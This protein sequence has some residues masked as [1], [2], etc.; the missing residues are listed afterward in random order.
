M[1]KDTVQ[2][3]LRGSISEQMVSLSRQ[4]RDDAEFRARM[5]ADPHAVLAGI[6]MEVPAKVEIR[7][8]RNTKKTLNLV[9]VRTGSNYLSDETMNEI[10][11]GSSAS[12]IGSLG[13]AA[14]ASTLPSTFSSASSASSAASAGCAG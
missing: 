5:D 4:Y 2:D 1:E 7:V 8:V 6:G 14:S 10:A 9:L 3:F 13:S 12:T 11:G